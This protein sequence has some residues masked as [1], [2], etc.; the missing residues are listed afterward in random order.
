M[1]TNGS[2]RRRP[3]A[4][5]AS[6]NRRDRATKRPA[7]KLPGSMQF[8]IPSDFAEGR[9]VQKT[10]LDAVE[11]RGFDSDSVF[12]VKLALEEA[13]I[14]AIKHGNKLDPG[15]KVHIEAIVSDREVRI[16]IEDEGP[17][18][19][20]QT[21]PDPTAE[22]NLTKCS[23]RGLLLMETYMTAVEYSNKGRKVCMVKHRNLVPEKA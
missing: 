15:K 2:N 14:N 18:F 22:E 19:D 7:R 13:M 23:G 5:N 1:G 9:V 6:P 8:V 21:V 11:R 20:R 12:A 16:I 4:K 3:S 17:G 10:I